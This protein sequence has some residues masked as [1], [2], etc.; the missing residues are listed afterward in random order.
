MAFPSLGEMKG[1]SQGG[2]GPVLLKG[3]IEKS[4]FLRE[5]YGDTTKG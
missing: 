4:L 2:G 3:Q 1:T 5:G